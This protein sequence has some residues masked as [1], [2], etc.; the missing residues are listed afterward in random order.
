MPDYN[1]FKECKDYNEWLEVNGELI[2]QMLSGYETYEVL[3]AAWFAGF[4]HGLDYTSIHD[5]NLFLGSSTLDKDTT[6]NETD[7]DGESV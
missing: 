3:Y 2:E 7:T 6:I 1:D 5:Q 4:C